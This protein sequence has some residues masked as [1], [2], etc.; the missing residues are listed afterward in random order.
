MALWRA[1]V[2]CPPP[3]IHS[4]ESEA[5]GL[6]ITSVCRQASEVLTSTKRVPWLLSLFL[7]VPEPSDRRL[8]LVLLGDH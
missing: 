4:V 8:F 6:T 3:H 2:N 1:A 7:E 5:R